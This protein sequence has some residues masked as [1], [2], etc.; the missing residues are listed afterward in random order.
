MC[1]I[2]GK[3]L[4][5]QPLTLQKDEFLPKSISLEL[6]K[7]HLFSPEYPP[8]A[9][10]QDKTRWLV[11]LH[12]DQQVPFPQVVSSLFEALKENVLKIYKIRQLHSK[13][14][15]LQ[16]F[17]S[18]MSDCVIPAVS[19]AEKEIEI[20]SSPIWQLKRFPWSSLNIQYILLYGECSRKLSIVYSN[21]EH[22]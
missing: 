1:N 11:A 5:S 20:L 18:L 17:L 3:V 13:T 15:C 6:G 7:A 9:H 14:Y 10:F 4:S 8:V 12:Q 19:F 22:T 21:R 2:R 16:T